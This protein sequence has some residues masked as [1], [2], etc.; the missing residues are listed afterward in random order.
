MSGSARGLKFY[1]TMEAGE[2]VPNDM[3]AELIR[4]IMLAKVIGSKVHTVI[5]M[6]QFS[7]ILNLVLILVFIY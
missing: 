5:S 4:E 7:L 6:F 2:P 1:K 3:M